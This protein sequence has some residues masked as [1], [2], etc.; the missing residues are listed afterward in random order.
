MIAESSVVEDGYK[1]VMLKDSGG[2]VEIASIGVVFYN[3]SQG[4]LEAGV[5]GT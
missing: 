3:L 5:F 1:G 2:L 4:R